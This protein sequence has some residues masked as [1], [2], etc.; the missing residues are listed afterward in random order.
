MKTTTLK[1]LAAGTL[2]LTLAAPASAQLVMKGYDIDGDGQLTGAEFRDLF[3]A[4]GITNVAAFDTDGDG[5]L[6]EAEYEAGFGAAEVKWAELGYGT[7]QY[8]D[9]DLNA[10]GLVSEE[11][12]ATGFMT[13]YDRD[14][15]GQ[16]DEAE[17]EAMDVDTRTIFTY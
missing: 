12:Y 4:D 7:F 9:W 13:I 8:T 16:I 14:K 3:D 5:F 15:S 6:S 17:F 10:D 2:A 1:A 11:E